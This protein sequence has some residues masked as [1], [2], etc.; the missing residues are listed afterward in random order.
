MHGAGASTDG[1]VQRNL[2]PHIDGKFQFVSGEL[3]RVR[4]RVRVRDGRELAMGR[5]SSFMRFAMAAT[6]I[7]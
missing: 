2:A 4:V 7:F 5:M 1:A 6:N 3:V